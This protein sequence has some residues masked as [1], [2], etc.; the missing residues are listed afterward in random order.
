MDHNEIWF[1]LYHVFHDKE[2]EKRKFCYCKKPIFL[3]DVN[4][5]KMFVSN[6]AFSNE[7]NYKVRPLC[8]ILPKLRECLYTL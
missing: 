3:E 5:D 4:I 7:E 6:K 2:I 8:I 1:F